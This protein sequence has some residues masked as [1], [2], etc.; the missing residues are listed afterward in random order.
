MSKLQNDTEYDWLVKLLIIGDSGVGKTNV[1]LRFCEDKFTPTHLTTIGIDFKMKKIEIDKSKIKLQVWDTAG[2]ERFRTITQ[3][4]Y[5]GAMGIIMTYSIN[6]KESFNNVEIWMKQIREQADSNVQKILIGNKCDLEA[7][8]QVTFYEGKSLADTFGI[9]FYETSAKNNINVYDAF[10]DICRDIKEKMVQQ[11][12][13][14]KQDQ[15]DI[16]NEKQNKNKNR[17]DVNV[18]KN[19]IL[20]IIIN[21]NKK[22]ITINIFEIVNIKQFY[23]KIQLF[24]NTQIKILFILKIIS[25]IFIQQY[26]RKNS[27][28]QFSFT[29]FYMLIIFYSYFLSYIIL[30]KKKQKSKYIY[31][32][33]LFKQYILNAFNF[34][35]IIFVCQRLIN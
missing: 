17:V 9:K 26:V 23:N 25:Y 1:L 30:Y 28:L 5:K 27:S 6:D 8:R 22:N 24:N 2:Q 31:F 14:N 13:L 29:Q 33:Y 10:I 20:Y 34:Q 12:S 18:E 32:L 3:N 16:Y 35:K 21:N 11:Q 19:N 15:F 7:E 4:Y